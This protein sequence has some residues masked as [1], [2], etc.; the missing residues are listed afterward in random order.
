MIAAMLGGNGFAQV[1]T[2][3]EIHGTVAD[4]SGA[5]VPNVQIKLVDEATGIERETT[6][7]RDGGFVFVTLPAG[8]Y[9]LTASATGF[10]TAVYTG[11]IVETGRARDVAIQLT[12]GETTTSVE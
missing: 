2:T 6:S 3:G 7:A 4:P 1:T 10:R 12:V 9:K 11:V 8:S 5:V